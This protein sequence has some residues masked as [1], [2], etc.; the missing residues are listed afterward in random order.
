MHVR[1]I[2]ESICVAFLAP[3][4]AVFA[5]PGIVAAEVVIIGC[6]VAQIHAATNGAGV[7]FA[8]YENLLVMHM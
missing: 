1:M 3:G 4:T 6:V 8:F 2:I 7:L 5:S